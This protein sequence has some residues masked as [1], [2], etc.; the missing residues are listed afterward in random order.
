[1]TAPGSVGSAGIVVRG[2]AAELLEFPGGSSM[3]LLGEGIG[4]DP[5]VTV[6]S[7]ILR[8]GTEGASPHHHRATTELIYVLD[9]SLQIL[10]GDRVLSAVAGDVVVIPP[11]VT[12]AFAAAGG[13]VEILDVTTPGAERFEHFRR[14]CLVARGCADPTTLAEGQSSH[15]AF[16]D[17]SPAW[18]QARQEAATP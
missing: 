8:H 10:V 3:R 14:L 5:T 12:H 4:T 13:D 7:A 16:A 6:H 2:T 18:I 17:D 1:M 15:D 11:R 9:G